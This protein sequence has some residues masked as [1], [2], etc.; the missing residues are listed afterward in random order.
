M[1][2]SRSIRHTPVLGFAASAKKD[3]VEFHRKLRRKVNDL[4][5]A[6]PEAEVYPKPNEVT[7]TRD[8]RKDPR[9]WTEDAWEVLPWL[10]RK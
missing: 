10:M 8:W 3:K 5:Q 1:L 6:E 9:L 7:N 2:V 4:L